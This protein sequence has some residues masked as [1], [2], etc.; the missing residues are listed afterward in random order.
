MAAS[1]P[2]P[3][4][5]VA[6]D[7]HSACEKL[8][9]GG[10][11][12]V[13][14]ILQ[15]ERA[16]SDG[17]DDTEHL[18]SARDDAVGQGT[19]NF[20]FGYTAAMFACSSGS[21]RC[22]RELV[23]RGASLD[24]TDSLF[25]TP[26]GIAIERGSADCVRFLLQDGLVDPFQTFAGGTTVF[27]A[28]KHFSMLRGGSRREELETSMFTVLV[29]AIPSHTVADLLK[30]EDKAGQTPLDYVPMFCGNFELCDHARQYLEEVLET[31]EVRC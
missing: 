30:M 11:E 19:G 22:L 28:A 6:R 31:A 29:D 9:D 24:A 26:L 1:P 16:R 4:H 15:R 2:P 14:E 23:A 25:T 21:E 10:W 12:R 17:G 18:L 27:H 13:A 3:W 20:Y 7:L 8:Q 5:A